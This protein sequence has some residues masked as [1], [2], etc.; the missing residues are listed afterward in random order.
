V[1]KPGK[2]SRTEVGRRG[3]SIMYAGWVGFKNSTLRK[4]NSGK[5]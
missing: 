4:K 5:E 3:R 1:G 2:E